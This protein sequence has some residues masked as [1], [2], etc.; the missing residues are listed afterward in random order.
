MTNNNANRISK[1]QDITGRHH[2][3]IALLQTLICSRYSLFGYTLGDG[4]HFKAYFFVDGTWNKYDGL[5][6][7]EVMSVEARGEDCL[8]E[9]VIVVRSNN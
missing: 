7:P 8:L 6:N 2:T 9:H 3:I 4:S 1:C 5:N